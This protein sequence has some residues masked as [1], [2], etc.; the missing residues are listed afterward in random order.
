[1]CIYVR[2]IAG[3]GSRAIPRHRGFFSPSTTPSFSPLTPLDPNHHPPHSH[4]LYIRFRPG[5]S[6]P[7]SFRSLV[8]FFFFFFLL[9]HSH[10]LWIRARGFLSFSLSRSLCPIVSFFFFLPLLGSFRTWTSKD[11]ID[12]QISFFFLSRF[13]DFFAFSFTFFFFFFTLQVSLLTTTQLHFLYSFFHPRTT[14]IYSDLAIYII[15]KI[16]I[17]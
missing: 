1:M 14:L 10:P 11:Q 16:S 2:Y 12:R 8:F 7:S 15:Y 5:A 4:L 3:R 17:L 6:T 9:F 13:R